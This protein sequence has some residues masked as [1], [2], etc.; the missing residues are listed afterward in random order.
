MYIQS[1]VV[2]VLLQKQGV[3]AAEEAGSFVVPGRAG[4]KNRAGMLDG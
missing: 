2:K 4:P 3:R 1:K